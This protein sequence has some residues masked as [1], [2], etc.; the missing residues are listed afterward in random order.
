MNI[1]TRTLVGSLAG[2][3]MMGTIGLGL[4]TA[5][6]A[7]ASTSPVGHYTDHVDLT[8][9]GSSGS[10]KLVLKAKT[11]SVD[12]S[13]LGYDLHGTWS[14]KGTTVTFNATYEDE[15]LVGVVKE[16]GNNLGSKADQGTLTL[17][18]SQIGTFYAIRKS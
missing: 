5:N 9:V 13:T 16:K 8:A 2:V 18:G 3:A 1:I 17:N 4:T 11:W 14:L 6:A 15:P 10:G 12:L 7:G